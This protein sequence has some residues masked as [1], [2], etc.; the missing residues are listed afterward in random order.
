MNRNQRCFYY[1]YSKDSFDLPVKVTNFMGLSRTDFYIT[2]LFYHY[3]PSYFYDNVHMYFHSA[4][5]HF[6]EIKKYSFSCNMHG[7]LF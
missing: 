7:W 6:D 3:Q 4:L 5:C 2:S 1:L